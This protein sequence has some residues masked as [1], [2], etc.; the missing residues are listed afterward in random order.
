MNRL[1]LALGTGLLM[2]SLAGVPVY[3]QGDP[4]DAQENTAEV[5]PENPE[6]QKE[7]DHTP[8]SYD[9]TGTVI[10]NIE[11]GS[12]HFY[13]ITTDAGNVFYLI[14]D[15][16][17]ES[18]N[19]YFLDTTKERDLLALA[20]KAEEEEGVTVIKEEPVAQ[21]ETPAPEPEPEPEPEPQPKKSNMSLWII[22]GLTAIAGIGVY[23]YYGIIKPKKD[24]DEAEEFE[25][26]SD[27]MEVIHREP[28]FVNDDEDD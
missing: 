21:V 15:L 8:I 9:G 3:A 4:N 6:P 23:V 7:D 28:S 1:S 13:T 18:N 20:E 17:K 27:F 2:F 16:D 22:L 10:D 25:E 26:N 24:A 11:N 14:V 12:K 19:V 5:L